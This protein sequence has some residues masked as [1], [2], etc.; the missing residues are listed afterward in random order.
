VF[1]TSQARVADGDDGTPTSLDGVKLHVSA[2]PHAKCERCWHYRTDVGSD[3]AHP[4]LCG[5]C[6]ANLYGDGE[7]RAH[8]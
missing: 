8:A 2:S 3:S 5:R 7:R 4:D 6:T 1:I